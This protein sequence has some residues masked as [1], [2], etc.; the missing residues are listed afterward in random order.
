MGTSSHR[1]CVSGVIGML[2]GG[3]RVVWLCVDEACLEGGEG[4]E[5][6]S[7]ALERKR[8]KNGNHFSDVD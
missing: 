3:G 8:E 1:D 2:K 6:L 4:R 5:N 7:L